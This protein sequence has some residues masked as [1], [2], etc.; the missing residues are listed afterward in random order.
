[1]AL[2]VGT[3]KPVN[4]T[5][6]EARKKNITGVSDASGMQPTA[7]RYNVTL[8]QGTINQTPGVQVQVPD[9]GATTTNTDTGTFTGGSGGGEV[10]PDAAA[11]AQLIE[12]L[13]A[14]R[15]QIE[16]AYAALF[17]DLDSLIK[18]REG[19]L[20]A[21]YAA[22]LGKASDQFADVLPTIDASY[23]A[24]GSYDS[25][26]R[27]DS[28][29]DAN[30]GYQDTVDTIGKNKD[31]DMEELG[32]YRKESRAKFAADKE[33]ALRYVD[34]AKDTTDV[35]ALR[36]AK[37]NLDTNLS[38]TKVT[39]AGLGTGASASK[40]LKGLTADNGRSNEALTALD[41]II[42][43]SMPDAVKDAA[44]EAVAASGAISEEDKKKVQS[45]Y[46]NVYA[47]QQA[48]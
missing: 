13:L 29:E 7:P 42:K 31:K 5:L 30:V 38:Q 33:S 16:Q 3:A 36:G 34:S 48:L 12:Q 6:G 24:L 22:Q 10:D 44:V 23:A 2:T 8:G 26:Q 9:A 1:M 37:N 35:D 19:E 17:G 18:E 11:R 47:E 25:T 46:G 27:G 28:R 40:E 4:L 21:D 39:R 41:S 43:S 14:K 20:E 15:D 45:Q 32:R